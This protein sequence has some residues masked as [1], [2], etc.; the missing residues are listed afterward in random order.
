M[1]S[2]SVIGVRP[3]SPLARASPASGFALYNAALPTAED[4]GG[5]AL[6]LSGSGSSSST[7]KRSDVAGRRRVRAAG[8]QPS[9]PRFR[10]IVDLLR[11]HAIW[12]CAGGCDSLAVESVCPRGRY[13]RLTF[14][15][16]SG[17]LLVPNAAGAI[18]MQQREWRV[19]PN[20]SPRDAESGRR[21][22]LRM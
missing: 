21:P 3:L 11:P 1:S 18:A 19:R 10:V 4:V 15:T 16:R 2:P 22:S 7:P 13:L 8:N 12:G 9:C 5:R 6:L 17:G 20:P 14:S